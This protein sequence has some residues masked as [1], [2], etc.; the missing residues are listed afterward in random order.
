MKTFIASAI[1]ATATLVASSSTAQTYKF[2]K[3]YSVMMK[4][5]AVARD[6]GMSASQVYQMGIDAGLSQEMAISL[7]N[8]VFIKGEKYPP[9]VLEALAFDTC[10]GEAT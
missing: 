4:S 6:N 10:M 7:I 8:V 9:V 2:C 1:V 3:D 5:V